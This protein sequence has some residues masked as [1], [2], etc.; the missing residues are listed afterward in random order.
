M[1]QVS[2]DTQATTNSSTGYD[3]D[4]TDR[5]VNITSVRMK[6]YIVFKRDRDN[7]CFVN[8]GHHRLPD[9]LSHSEYQPKLTS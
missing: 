3:P 8:A 9:L 2:T 1:T 7:L 6:L 4:R 5:P